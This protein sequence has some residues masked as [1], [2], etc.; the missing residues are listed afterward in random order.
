MATFNLR[1]GL[2]TDGRIDLARVAEVITACRADIVALQELDQGMPRSHRVDQPAELQRLTGLSVTFHPTLERSGGRF[3]LAVAAAQPPRVRLLRLPRTRE[4]EPRAVLEA[5]LAPVTVL[6]TH[7]SVHPG[8]R[9][10]QLEALGELAERAPAPVAVVG[11]LNA[12]RAELG[13]LRRRGFVPTR[14]RVTLPGRLL[15]RQVDHVL[16]G[17]GMAHVRSFTLRTRASD[18]RPL[19]ADLVCL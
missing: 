6:A 8:E 19:V 17:P 13:A 9:V 5:R 15:R 10:I 16:A 3:G 1:H 4:R 11:D 18:H 14:Y 12:T 7:L 2:G